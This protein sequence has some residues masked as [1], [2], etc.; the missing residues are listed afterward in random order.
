MNPR[1]SFMLRV[2]VAGGVLA[3]AQARAAHLEESDETATALG[4]KHDTKLVDAAKYPT[5]AAEQSCSHCQF[6]QG[7]AGDAWAG[8]A[9]FGRKQV[10]SGGWCSA[11]KKV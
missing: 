2:A 1:R 6:W 5:H 9:M 10:S 7:A 3:S 11:F 8:C 4:Y